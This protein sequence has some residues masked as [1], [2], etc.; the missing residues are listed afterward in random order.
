MIDVL[1][2]RE[3]RRH[4]DL[5][6]APQLRM[7]VHRRR[8]DAFQLTLTENHAI[9]DG[10]SLHSTLL[11]MFSLYSALL[12]G[13]R[14]P[15]LPPPP[16]PYREFVA[17][18]RATV[19]GEA[20]RAYWE[21]RLAAAQILDLPRWPAPEGWT[22]P[23]VESVAPPLAVE[24]SEGLKRLAAL[25]GVPLKAVCLAAHLKVL[26]T[27]AA[28]DDVLTGVVTHG[29]PEKAGAEETR[30]LFLNTLPLRFQLAPGT[31]RELVL[32]TFAAE[33]EMMPHRRFPLSELQKRHGA[34]PLFEVLFNFTH[35]HVVT[36]ILQAGELRV[37]G[38]KKSEE[39]DLTLNVGFVQ[40]P[41]T[42]HLGLDL[43]HDRTS[44]PRAE[45]QAIHGLY[46]RVLAAMAADRDAR[47]DGAALLSPAER[48]Q[49]V[50][51][52][53]DTG[54]AGAPELLWAPFARIAAERPGALALVAG[55]RRLTYGELDGAAEPAG[56][57]P[58]RRSASGR[59]CG[60]GSASSA[61][62][63]W[64][65]ALLG[66]LKA[67]GAYVPLDPAYPAER[68]ALHRSRTPRR[69]RAA[70]PRRRCRGPRCRRARGAAV[71]L[72]AH[73]GAERSPSGRA[74]ARRGG[75]A[76]RQ[77][78]LRDLHLGLDRAAQGG[79]DR[80]PQ[81]R[82]RCSPGR[83]AVFADRGARAG[84]SPRPRSASTS[85]SSSS[86]RRSA[87]GGTV[88]PR[89]ERPRPA[90][91]A[92]G[93]GEVTLVNTVPSAL[94]ELLR[95]GGAAASVAT[96][97]LAGEPL[98]RALVAAHL[99][100]ARASSG[101]STSTARPRT[102]PTRPGALDRR[103][104]AGAPPIG[105]PIAGTQAYVL[106]RRLAAGAGRGRRRALPRRRRARPRLPR[107]AGADR[108]ALRPRPVRRPSRAA[109]LYRTGDLARWRAGRR[110]RVPRPHRPPGQGARLPHRAG[111]DRGGPRR[112]S[113]GARGG[114]ASR[115]EDGPG[116]QRLVAYVVAAGGAEPGGSR[117][118]A[119]APARALPGVHGARPPSCCSPRCR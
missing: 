38:F 2:E 3:K 89:R 73:D 81:R 31:W 119:R 88:D 69:R 92:G 68:L 51:E 14:P 44:I 86:S 66:V 52:W 61:R 70:R 115:R 33:Q 97:N 93:R 6:R 99:R 108:R 32:Q 49:I 90:R 104:T 113:G 7:T 42:E 98:P 8:D 13:E 47:H 53:N 60:W 72:D 5:E 18:E 106:D 78:R 75:A 17:L 84:C 35:F 55:E 28:T 87:C 79:G 24:I 94:A 50:S 26:A 39:T 102:P 15:V 12:A 63:S 45:A 1:V 48:Q 85:R 37:L 40:N 16:I 41:L 22:G 54:S 36:E 74:R 30:G 82:R 96:V 62:R 111:G 80:A 58:A 43:A 10:W 95:A 9:L 56:A 23:R 112:A 91:A 83:A 4:F 110:A 117:R 67:G 71:C 46:L 77:P 27:L 19:E 29:R 105:R 76:P 11:K 118:C 20:A 59:R 64:W 107:P 65:S 114:G 109:R 101:S 21:G 116:D 25:A 34:R 103:A 57:P 100:A